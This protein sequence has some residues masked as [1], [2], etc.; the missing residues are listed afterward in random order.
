MKGNLMAV[1]KFVAAATAIFVSQL[2]LAEV[3]RH[4]SVEVGSS[5]A[6]EHYSIIYADDAGNLRMETYGATATASS[7][8]TAGGDVEVDYSVGEL[9]GVMIFQ[10]AEKRMLMVD[11]GQCQVMSADM[12]GMPPGGME[13][14]R[15]EMAAAQQQMQEAMRDMAE[16]D[17]AMARML[18]ERMASMGG[19]MPGMTQQRREM[20]VEESDEDRAIGDYSTSLFIVYEEGTDRFRTSVWAADI[21][22]V[23]GGRIV[24][25]AMKGWFEH[26]RDVMD[27]MGVG[28]M[29]GAGLTSAILEK[30]DSYYPVMTESSDRRTTLT[31]AEIGGTANFYPDCS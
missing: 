14:Y 29:S 21:D 9:Q 26:F 25:G 27:R 12:A 17:P 19:G 6:P 20:V 3:A 24:G 15:E 8:G 18:E 28:S 13:Q 16:Q 1:R 7:S 11:G 23:E 5:G 31:S 22:D 2:A 4:E 10:A 30:M